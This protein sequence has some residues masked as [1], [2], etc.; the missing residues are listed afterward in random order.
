MSTLYIDRKYTT[1]THQ[2]ATLMLHRQGHDP[3]YIPLA[4][5]ERVVVHGKVQTDTATLGALANAGIAVALLSG[6][7]GR[8]KATLVGMPGKDVQRRL[9]QY[10]AWHDPATRI[11][12]ATCI[13]RRKLAAQQRNL[14]RAARLR[15]D[16]RHPFTKAQSQLQAISRQLKIQT[17][18]LNPLRGL[19]G[20]AATAYFSAYQHLFPAAL[21]FS[22]RKRR[23]PPDPVNALLSLGYTLLHA[24]AVKTAHAAGLDPYLGFLH[25]PAHGRE[26]LAA[27]L[28][29][30]LRPRYDALVW[31]I[32]RKRVLRAQDFI[33]DDGGCRLKKTAR[34]KFYGLYEHQAA[35]ARRWLR[36]FTY[37]LIRHITRQGANEDD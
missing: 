26:S 37:G 10:R 17:L 22:G 5:L 8:H 30:P 31:W 13:L 9:A 34:G 16:L 28:I 24:E 33:E 1:M 6:R 7:H 29:E 3:Q 36:R 15:P 20:S 23:P 14:S 21:A 27:D 11:Q 25:E 12:I 2:G 19:E 35:P 32:F 18:E 4:M